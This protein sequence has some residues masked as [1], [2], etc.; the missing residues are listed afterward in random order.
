MNVGIDISGIQ[1]LV[2]SISRNQFKELSQKIVEGT[3][4]EVHRNIH[5]LASKNL[6]QTRQAYKRNINNP[7]FGRMK[8]SI[9]LTGTL[10]NMIEKG[11]SPFDMKEGFA[12]SKKIK[13]TKSGGWYLTIPFRHASSGSLGDSEVFSGVMPKDIHDF[14][15][16]MKATITVPFIG[17]VRKGDSITAKDLAGSKHGVLGS[18][19][20][21]KGMGSKGKAYQHKSPIYAGLG[22]SKKFYQVFSQG[23]Y[24]TFRRVGS[25]SAQNSWIHKGMKKRNFF[26]K[27][28]NDA[29]LDYV[30]ALVA[31][32]Y[33][34]QAGIWQ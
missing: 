31:D 2:G 26:G 25:G 3:T 18:R 32:N 33:M 10:P 34:E 5:L 15:K 4:Y 1:E 19:D 30:V 27:A 14:A 12:R 17:V 13:K 11:A 24:S 6:R 23:S 7:V 20:A 8:G 21:I 29:K 28:V 9:T 16:K 22:R